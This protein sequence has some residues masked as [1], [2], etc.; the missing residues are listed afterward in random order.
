MTHSEVSIPPSLIR[1]SQ[2]SLGLPLGLTRVIRAR[3]VRAL[4]SHAEC[5]HSRP[6]RQPLFLMGGWADAG[7]SIPVFELLRGP[8]FTP[9]VAIRDVEWLPQ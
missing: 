4:V 1:L 2:G 6:V 8:P 7:F 9:P 5:F 3:Q